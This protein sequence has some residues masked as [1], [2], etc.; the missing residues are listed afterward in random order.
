MA[1]RKTRVAVVLSGCGHL[2]GSEIHE[3]VAT[4]YHLALHGADY[5]CFAPDRELDEVD[6]RTGQPT[7]QRRSLLREA[8]RIARGEIDDLKQLAVEAFDAVI[9]PGGYGAARNLSDFAQRGAEATVLPE[10][11]GVIRAF[12]AQQKPIGVICI[13]PAVLAV[14]LKG[15]GIKVR[16][17]LGATCGASRTVEALGAQHEECPVDGI[18]VDREQRIVSSPAYMYDTPITGPFAGIGKLVETLLTLVRS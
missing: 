16:L 9:F 18:V 2:D 3:T 5:R 1:H 10:I 11:V 7:G 17:T 4:L 13:A 6:H 14:A 8:A 12:H 15:T